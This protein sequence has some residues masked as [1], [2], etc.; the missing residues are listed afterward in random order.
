MLPGE[1]AC[2]TGIVNNGIGAPGDIS[3]QVLLHP[4]P[5]Q[6]WDHNGTIDIPTAQTP[7]MDS[8]LQFLDDQTNAG[9]IPEPMIWSTA[10]NGYGTLLGDPTAVLDNGIVI[11]PVPGP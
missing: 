3:I 2:L 4:I 11:S 1:V 5:T 7:T 10:G 6:D 8:Y 9:P